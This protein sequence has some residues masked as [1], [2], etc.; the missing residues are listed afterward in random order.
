MVK[1]K[2]LFRNPHKRA[3]KLLLLLTAMSF[4]RSAV[5]RQQYTVAA[6]SGDHVSSRTLYSHVEA[7]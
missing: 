1:K 7:L 3:H 6:A 2:F 4:E 5:Q